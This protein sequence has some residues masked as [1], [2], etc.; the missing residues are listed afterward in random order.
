MNWQLPTIF[1]GLNETGIDVTG[2]KLSSEGVSQFPLTCSF[3]S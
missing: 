1:F 2:Q 3:N